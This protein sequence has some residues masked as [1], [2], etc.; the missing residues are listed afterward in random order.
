MT[1]YAILGILHCTQIPCTNRTF[2]VG[3]WAQVGLMK[4]HPTKYENLSQA[5]KF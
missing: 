5:L 4:M 2:S 1:L 3:D